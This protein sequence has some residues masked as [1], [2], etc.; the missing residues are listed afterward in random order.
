MH[1]IDS[2]LASPGC[3]V[4][5]SWTNQGN[6]KS[7][8]TLSQGLVALRLRIGA[9]V[10]ILSWGPKDST[11][12]SVLLGGL[13]ILGFG[14]WDDRVNL[15]YRIKL[16][17]QMV[18]ALAVIIIGGIRFESIP[19]LLDAELPIVDWNSRHG[20]LPCRRLECGESHGRP[21]RTGWR[22]FLL[23]SL[24][25][26]LPGL[27]RQ[28][29]DGPV[30]DHSVPRRPVRVSCATTPI[31]LGFSWETVAV[32]CLALSWVCWPSS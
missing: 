21:R 6:A 8:S 28:R 3:S 23:D 26:C 27:P 31:R 29:F 16:L 7:T 12:L 24:R 9:F 1:G 4:P 22:A 25:D 19:F 17:G 14:V 32:S 13:I 20:A 11:T 15:G 10:S 30:A 2:A 5:Y 18:A